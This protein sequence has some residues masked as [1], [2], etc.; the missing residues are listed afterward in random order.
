MKIKKYVAPTLKEATEQMKQELGENAIILSTRIIEG[1]DSYGS[2]KLFEIT[3]GFEDEHIPIMKKNMEKK[4]PVD[5]GDP[6]AFAMELKKLA[7]KI[8]AEKNSI[9]LDKTDTKE[10]QP[11]NNKQTKGDPLQSE[12]KTVVDV[13]LENDVQKNVISLVLKELKKNK[14]FLNAGNINSYVLSSISSFIPT[15]NFEVNHKNKSKVVALVG[16]TGVGKTTSI[17][18]LAVI[19]KILHNLDIGLISIDTYRLGALDQLRIFSEVSNIE[20]LVAYEPQEMPNLINSFKKK[21]IIFVDTVGRSQNNTEL[22]SKTKQFLDAVDVDEIVLVLSATHATKNLISIADKFKLFGYD[23]L[24]FTK[25]DEAVTYGNILNVAASVNVPTMFLTN[26]QVIPDDIISA[27]PGM[28]AKLIYTG[29]L[30]S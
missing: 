4:E 17:A 28:I 22:L 6:K 5:I 8:Y 19:S 2:R 27:D 12:L 29:V 13:L 3:S 7:S 21:D 20:M 14:Q 11:K 24:L 18:K 1:N 15:I 26:G 9:T 10:S 16:P 23:S 30:G 25:I